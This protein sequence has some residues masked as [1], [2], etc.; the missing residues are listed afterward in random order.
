MIETEY[1]YQQTLYR[2]KEFKA[3]LE[4]EKDEYLPRNSAMYRMLSGGTV[5]Q[6][7]DLKNDIAEY[8]SR[9]MKKAS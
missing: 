2:L 5:A 1:G 7:E 9:Q 8:E 3:M 4:R 6:I